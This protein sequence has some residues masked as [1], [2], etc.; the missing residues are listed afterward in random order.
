MAA[1]AKRARG[2]I[3]LPG[4]TAGTRPLRFI[5]YEDVGLYDLEAR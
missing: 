3:A 5:L 1:N 4:V 2:R